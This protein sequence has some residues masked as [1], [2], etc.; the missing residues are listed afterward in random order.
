MHSDRSHLVERIRRDI[1]RRGWPRIV[2]FLI[3]SLAGMCGFLVSYALLSAGITSMP[4]RYGIAGASAYAGFL[5]FL[6]LYVA[7]RRGGDPIDGVD[8]V[9]LL[10]HTDLSFGGGSLPSANFAGGR[11]GGAGASAPFDGAPPQSSSASASV[12]DLDS[13]LAWVLVAV[14][15]ALAGA[16]AIGYVVWAAPLLLAEV[17]VDAA[18]VSTVSRTINRKDRRD[19]TATAIR[20][21]WMPAVA[22]ILTLV[23]AGWALQSAAPDARSIGPALRAVILN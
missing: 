16:V 14:L 21:T 10:S 9:D 18:I 3:V 7:M 2:V 12:F 17:L 4:L 20:R 11:S 15:A 22:L 19:W 23:V 6:G 13:D 8:A 1:E 5:A